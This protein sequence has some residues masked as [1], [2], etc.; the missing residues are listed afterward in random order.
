M[1]SKRIEIFRKNQAGPNRIHRFNKTGEN[2]QQS[3]YYAG[4]SSHLTYAIIR[5]KIS[6]HE[7]MSPRSLAQGTTLK[8]SSLA[9]WSR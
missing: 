7:A 8:E 6:S 1:Q 3:N 9:A 4:N 2:K 5:S